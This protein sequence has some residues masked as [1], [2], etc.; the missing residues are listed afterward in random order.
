[1][2]ITFTIINT[3]NNIVFMFIT[4]Y[5]TITFHSIPF[6]C[7][8]YCPLHYPCHC[9]CHIWHCHHHHH[10][11]HCHHHCLLHVLVLSVLVFCFFF[12]SIL[13]YLT[14]WSCC[15]VLINCGLFFYSLM[16]MFFVTCAMVSIISLTLLMFSWKNNLPL[17]CH[18]AEDMLH[19]LH[20]Y[21]SIRV[22]VICFITLQLIV[23]LSHFLSI[24]LDNS[25]LL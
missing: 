19:L 20:V 12:Y 25:M 8:W 13:C 21:Y 23:E 24:K 1:M 4:F 7:P 16:Q 15:S 17:L 2:H 3:Q 10:C 14:Y 22:V 5:F 11:H 18:F 9:L 6:H